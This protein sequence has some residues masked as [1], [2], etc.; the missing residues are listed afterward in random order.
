MTRLAQFIT[1]VFWP[2]RIVGTMGW[3]STERRLPVIA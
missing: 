2:N 3:S 1:R